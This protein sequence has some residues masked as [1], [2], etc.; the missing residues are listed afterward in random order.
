MMRSRDCWSAP[1]AVEGRAPG[2]RSMSSIDGSRRR[3][4]NREAGA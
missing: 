2:A 1:H 3:G 4:A